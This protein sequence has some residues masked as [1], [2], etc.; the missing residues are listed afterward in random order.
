MAIPNL[1]LNQG[2]IALGVGAIYNGQFILP[3]PTEMAFGFISDTYSTCDSYSTGTWVVYDPKDAFQLIRN[4]NTYFIID[5]SK[6][7]CYLN[8]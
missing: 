4:N 3:A 5:E 6:I 7:K 8:A 1:I 2:Q